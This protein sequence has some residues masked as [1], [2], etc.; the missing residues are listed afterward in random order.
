MYTL[1]LKLSQIDKHHR[2]N[3]LQHLI[4]FNEKLRNSFQNSWWCMRLIIHSQLTCYASL[5]ITNIIQLLF[6]NCFIIIKCRGKHW[7]TEVELTF[8]SKFVFFS[9]RL[10]F[11]QAVLTDEFLGPNITVVLDTDLMQLTTTVTT[12]HKTTTQHTFHWTT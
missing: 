1:L 4:V 10:G 9:F 8:C 2:L 11:I 6:G 5:G 12:Y 7:R 3:S